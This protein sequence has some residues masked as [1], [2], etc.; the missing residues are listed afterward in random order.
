[1]SLRT[2]LAALVLVPFCP[3]AAAFIIP[4]NGTPPAD[5]VIEYLNTGTGHYFYTWSPGDQQALDSG[6]FGTGWVRTGQG[7]GA[8]GTRE[9]GRNSSYM[10][11]ACAP[12][13]AC[14]PISR[15]YAPGPNS[16]FF[17]G[18]AGDVA[19]LDRPG[20]GWLLENVAFYAAMPS[21]SGDCPPGKTPVRRLYNNRAALNDSNHRYTADDTARQVMVARGW[22]DEGV[23]FCAYGKRSL[24]TETHSFRV[25][26]VSEIMTAG[27][28]RSRAARGSCL[29]FAGLPLPT[30]PFTSTSLSTE[31]DEFDRETGASPFLG[32]LTMA[33]DG[34]SRAAAAADAFVQIHRS[35]AQ[36]GIHVSPRSRSGGAYAS[37]A[38]LRRLDPG[39]LRPYNFDTGT[40]REL[41]LRATVMVQESSAGPD[42]HSYGVFTWQFRD[43]ASGRS[44]LFNAI[45]FGTLPGGEGAGRDVNTSLPFV[46]ATF[47]TDGRFGK[48]WGGPP[49]AIAQQKEPLLG[50]FQAWIGRAH[51]QAILDAARRVDPLLSP[52]PAD[53]SVVNFGLVNEV[54]GEGEIGLVVTDISLSVK[55]A[56]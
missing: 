9:R 12:Q 36:T 3:V 10:Q 32:A 42:G 6:A 7:F 34:T 39:A 46:Y 44:L 33:V 56:D 16:H 28:C 49:R 45:A 1:M 48:L 40:E 23:A 18:S 43:E 47:G 25:A 51:F 24:T 26:E 53:Y 41:S 20:S 13:G 31:R 54:F 21:A 8:F 11:D 38:A 50:F 15:F 37:I 17:T 55:G 52:R 22:V 5:S 30:H 2:C 14:L 27:E 19:I 35:L 29:G 4:I